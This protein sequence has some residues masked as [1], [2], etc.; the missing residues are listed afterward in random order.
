MNWVDFLIIAIILLSAGI[1]IIRGFVRE[2][3]SLISWVLAFW[4][5]LT[6]YTYLAGLLVPYIDTLSIRL[7][8]AFFVLFAVTL[9]LG[10]LVNHTIA[11]LVD[12]T[13]LSGTDR[14]LG[15]IFGLLRGIAIVTVLVIL[16]G[17]TPMPTD[18]WWQN[19]LL[20]PQFERLATWAL[21]FVPADIAAHVNF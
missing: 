15:V 11:Q 10:A 14:A 9:I 8:A 13:G 3:L 18:D 20:L 12:K 2:V 19:A 1:S 5:A 4:V 6:F 16:A 17:L 21:G 7:F